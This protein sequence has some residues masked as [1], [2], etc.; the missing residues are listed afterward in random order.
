MKDVR[1]RIGGYFSVLR[2]RWIH[3]N[4]PGYYMGQFVLL[5]SFLVLWPMIDEI[6]N[7]GWEACVGYYLTAVPILLAIFVTPLHPIALPKLLYLCPMSRE[8]RKRELWK[9][10][11]FKIAVPTVLGICMMSVLVV[12]DIASLLFALLTV[13]AALLQAAC[14]GSM[15]TQ[16]LRE[17]TTKNGNIMNSMSVRE[18]VGRIVAILCSW[19]YMLLCMMETREK[20]WGGNSIIAAFVLLPEI[21]VAVGAAKRAV[22]V[23]EQAMQYED[24]CIR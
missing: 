21:P 5:W 19:I 18:F 17:W 2:P 1:I 11:L 24:A 13:L 23:V 12:L 6:W 8:E 9:D 14:S 16:K 20:V 10:Y 4:Y 22:R 7:K 15:T 3:E